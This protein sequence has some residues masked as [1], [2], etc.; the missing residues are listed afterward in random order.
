MCPGHRTTIGIRCPASQAS[1]FIPRNGQTELCFRRFVSAG[2]H[3]GPL[4]LVKTTSVC[5]LIFWFFNA[6]T[7]APT[8]ASTIIAKSP[9]I[10]APLLPRNFLEGNHGV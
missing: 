2:Y 10:E 1:P 5:W 6:P 9:Y 7:I 4:S 3:T 8:V